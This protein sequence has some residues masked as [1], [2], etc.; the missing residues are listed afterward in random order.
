MA[1]FGRFWL[2]NKSNLARK[3]PGPQWY[4]W[5][6]KRQD[7]NSYLNTKAAKSC[8]EK[9]IGAEA[10]CGRGWTISRYRK[11]VIIVKWT[12]KKVKKDFSRENSRKHFE[13]FVWTIFSLACFFVRSDTGY[14]CT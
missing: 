14:V 4:Q 1:H 5:R 7:L 8:T 9:K 12:S 13:Q 11:F 6:S 2:G 3:V 10:A